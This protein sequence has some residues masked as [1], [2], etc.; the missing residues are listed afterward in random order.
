MYGLLH[1]DF[2]TLM[3]TI[4][5]YFGFKST[6]SCSNTE[7]N[8][9]KI[10]RPTVST[11]RNIYHKNTQMLESLKVFNTATLHYKYLFHN[12]IIM[13]LAQVEPVLLLLQ[14][15][16]DTVSTNWQR[17]RHADYNSI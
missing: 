2:Y 9:I 13:G 15:W 8:L 4:L 6:V 1:M 16:K 12:R 3:D 17:G 7:W 11:E 10:N 5:I 14:P